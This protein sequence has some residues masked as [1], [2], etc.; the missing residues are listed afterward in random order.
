MNWIRRLIGIFTACI[1]FVTG[2]VTDPSTAFAATDSLAAQNHQKFAKDL[3]DYLYALPAETG[4]LSGMADG[5]W[6][7]E[8]NFSR[9]PSFFIHLQDAHANP[10]AQRNIHAILKYL[11][12]RYPDC[13][14]GVEGAAG[15]L[16]PENLDFP[17]GR[18]NQ[19]HQHPRVFFLFAQKQQICGEFFA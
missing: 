1:F 6:R 16:H 10:D 13:V 12:D 9:H 15:P 7:M 8:K 5:G 2:V 11:T 18:L 4:S 17:I 3:Q 19:G 14:I